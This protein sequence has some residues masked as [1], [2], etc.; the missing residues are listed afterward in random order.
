[1]KEKQQ[2]IDRLTGDFIAYLKSIN[3]SQSTIEGY[4]YSWGKLKAYMSTRNITVFSKDIVEEFLTFLFG[5]YSYQTLLPGQKR[6]INEL[7]ALGEFQDEG[8]IVRSFK[9]PPKVFDGSIGEYILDYIAY[10][11]AA[12]NSAERTIISYHHHLHVFLSFLRTK[13]VDDIQK[14][15]QS[16]VYSFIESLDKNKLATK[17]IMA[18]MLKNFFTYLSDIKKIPNCLIIIPPQVNYKQS[19]RLPSTFTKDEISTL[20]HCVD[21]AN[22]RGK[23]DYAILLLAVKLGMRS[24]DIMGLRFENILWDKNLIKFTQ[25]KT[26][27]DITLPLMPEIGNAIIDYFKYGR[28]ESKEDFCFLQAVS[29]YSPMKY[30][31]VGSLTQ[32]HLARSGI[33]LR[34]RK[35]GPHALRHSF[36]SQLL[37]QKTPLPII[38]EAMGHSRT[39]STMTYLRIDSDTLRQC[40]LEVPSI[41][42]SFYPKRGGNL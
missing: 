22:P 5:E 36:A 10:R 38:S 14:I 19:P 12:F 26:G 25:R 33:N 1:M 28:Q 18:G 3:R 8:R 17:C 39:Q 27:K 15:T 16:V 23:R 11:K 4:S 31:E 40:A 37:D 20:L 9:I 34:G 2:T 24:S 13:G 21:R 7:L 35:H 30:G 6:M 32:Q 41:P 42:F 29:P